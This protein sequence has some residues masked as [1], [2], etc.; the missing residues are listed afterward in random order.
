MKTILQIAID[1]PVGAGKSNISKNIAKALG[2]TF[3]YTGAMYRALAHECIKRDV[4]ENNVPE[5]VNVLKSISIELT[6][7]PIDSHFPVKVL[8][9][10]S[11]V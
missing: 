9:R 6:P 4:Y 3:V 8:D 1:G 11:V 2:I 5:I 7:A 10:K